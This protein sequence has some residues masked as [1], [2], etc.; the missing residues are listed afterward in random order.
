MLVQ[1]NKELS[2]AYAAEEEFWR[3]RSR[4]TW[5]ALGDQNSGYFHSSTKGR[6]EA[7]N[8]TVLESDQ[9][10]VVYEDKQ[11][12]KVISLCYQNLFTSQLSNPEEIRKVVEEAVYPK[13][14]SDDNDLKIRVRDPNSLEV[15][16]ALFDI[17]PDKAPSRDGSSAS[18][19]QTNWET[20]GSALVAE[21]QGYFSSGLLPKETNSTH[22]RLIPKI[23][24][25]KKVLDYRP[26]ALCKCCLQSLLQGFNKE[27]QEGTIT[28][29]LL[30]P[31]SVC[32]NKGNITQ[33]SYH[34]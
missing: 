2:D 30:E 22:I 17:H 7:N 32:G 25:P 13:I 8:L 12:A 18:F 5:R 10:E 21:I 27:T 28:S 33:C 11:F 4:Q 26:I 19:F 34:S 9:G 29:N 31:V 14:S 1:L 23:F 6:L 15:K 20:A 3:Q 16:E 24:E